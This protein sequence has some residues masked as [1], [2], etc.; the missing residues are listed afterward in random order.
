M[1]ARFLVCL[2]AAALQGDTKTIEIR[3]RDGFL[4]AEA[5]E[6]VRIDARGI[7]RLGLSVREIRL[8]D[9]PAVWCAAGSWAGTTSGKIYSIR[10]GQARLEH[11]TGEL[12]VTALALRGRELFASTIPSGKVF[13]RT[14]DGKWSVHASLP[15]R[16]VWDL[17]ESRGELFAACGDPAALVRIT[18]EGAPRSVFS[19]RADH[20]LC[21][22]PEEEGFWIGTSNPGQLIDTRSGRTRHDF[23]GSEVRCLVRRGEELWAAANTTKASPAELVKSAHSS[24][25]VDPIAPPASR[26]AIAGALWRFTKGRADEL[27]VFPATWITAMARTEQGVGVGTNSGGR[28]YQFLPDGHWEMMEDFKSG[29][30]CGFDRGSAGLRVLLGGRGAVAECSTT[31]PATGAWTSN[32]HDAGYVSE[33]GQVQARGKG[34]FD[35]RFRSGLSRRPPEGWSDWSAPVTRWPAAIPAPK[36]RYLQIRVSLS[37]PAAEVSEIVFSYRNE[38]QEPKLSALKV[39]SVALSIPPEAPGIDTGPRPPLHSALKNVSW[40]AKDPDGD[41]L[42]YFLEYRSVDSKLWVAAGDGK[43]LVQPQVRWD[44]DSI[45]DGRYVLRV[46]ASDERS[47][48]EGDA[49]STLLESD[50][51]LIDNSKPRLTLEHASGRI[52]GKAIDGSSRIARLEMQVDG[53]AWQPFPCKDGVFDGLS[54]E[55]DAALPELGP[56]GHVVLVRAVDEEMN[57]T[58]ESVEIQVKR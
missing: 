43:P 55:F 40:E 51:F 2:A 57:F 56:G 37:D 31:P 6:R 48:R 13:R 12:A 32:V 49:L 44:T 50:P 52:R 58:V 45:P 16:Y 28:V 39:E 24:T 20:V 25:P 3:G 41:A 46:R 10:D 15:S 53:G 21:A 22:V 34:R 7:L 4:R 27:A 9:E 11:D 30:I 1:L 23:Q 35:L 8:G 36:G 17:I 26:P 54:E 29:Q 19:P 38:N 47:N 5:L 33:W 14:P 18:G 42:I